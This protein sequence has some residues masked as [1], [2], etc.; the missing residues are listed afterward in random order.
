MFGRLPIAWLLGIRRTATNA[1]DSITNRFHNPPTR[2]QSQLGIFKAFRKKRGSGGI[3]AF[4]LKA[5]RINTHRVEIDEPGFEQRL[6]G[7]FQ[8]G[9]GFA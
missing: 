6:G 7:G 1:I 8:G 2:Y 3:H 5:F 4:R 9:V